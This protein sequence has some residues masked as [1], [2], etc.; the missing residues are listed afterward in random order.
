MVMIVPDISDEEISEELGRINGY[1][2][3]IGATIKEVLTDSPWGRRRLAYSIRHNSIDYRDGYYVIYHFDT[4]PDSI[5]DLERE[6]KLDVRVIRYLLVHDD[7][8]WG[9][10]NQNNEEGGDGEQAGAAAPSA[11]AASAPATP[12]VEAPAAETV[13]EAAPAEDTV[14]AVETVAE[15]APAEEATPVEESAPEDAVVEEAAPVADVAENVASA[16]EVAPVAETVVDKAP[17][18]AAV[19]PEGTAEEK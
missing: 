14:T 15:A 4:V 11:P 3:D 6:L 13:T 9:S 18:V 16:E 7:P 8:K 2:G 1:I 19:T 5:G 17:E 12:V 10:Q